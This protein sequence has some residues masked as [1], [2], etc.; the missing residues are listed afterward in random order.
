VTER[1]PIS[2]ALRF[3]VL[4]RDRFTCRYCG[5][6]PP[7]VELVLDH[8]QSV[9]DGGST[10]EQN[11]TTSCADCNAGKG[12]AS[13]RLGELRPRS[14]ASEADT[15]LAEYYGDLVV[16]D[17]FGLGPFTPRER[18]D[19]MEEFGEDLAEYVVARG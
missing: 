4:R 17:A 16:A 19:L 13:L 10:D 11:L 5:A 14:R 1:A 3:R 2:L 18:L 9:A 15:D 6:H 7:F 12:A 8:V